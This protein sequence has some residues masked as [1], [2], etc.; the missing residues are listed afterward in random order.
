MK[1]FQNRTKTA[2]LIGLSFQ[3]GACGA[4]NSNLDNEDLSTSASS[5][6]DEASD[7]LFEGSGNI[8]IGGSSFEV[9]RYGLSNNSFGFAYIYEPLSN[10]FVRTRICNDSNSSTATVSVATSGSMSS[11]LTLNQATRE[12]N[13]TFSGS[14]TRLWTPANG[15]SEIAC[16]DS[17]KWVSLDWSNNA[18]VAGLKL[19]IELN[20]MREASLVWTRGSVSKSRTRN[21]SV[22][23]NR[24]IN[25]VSS[26][27]NNGN[28]VIE[29]NVATDVTRKRTVTKAN[30]ESSEFEINVKSA[31]NA[32]LNVL[33]T[34][35]ATSGYT[36][37][38]KEIKSGT[39]QVTRGASKLVLIFA[40]VVYSLS[41]TGRRC[42]PTSGT[43]S[44]SYFADGNSS[45]VSSEFN[46]VFSTSADPVMTFTSS[47]ESFDLD[48]DTHCDLETLN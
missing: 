39:L 26:S 18:V 10:T 34:R 15:Q 17:N 37:L 23:G 35:N 36:A 20:R 47:S 31:V 4:L 33:V 40:N 8:S 24:E 11:S 5:I 45:V 1:F 29:K 27:S 12:L 16:A 46:I 7:S 6:L 38:Q 22:A 28:L 48:L 13:S 32:P 21:L 30:G 43:I 41:S 25:F 9:S 14:E 42:I 44:G 3:L 19:N 2:L